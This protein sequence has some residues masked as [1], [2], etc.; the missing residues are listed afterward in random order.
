MQ[1]L[2]VVWAMTLI[3]SFMTFTASLHADETQLPTTK[4]QAVHRS[5]RQPWWVARQKDLVIPNETRIGME[6]DR[7][8]ILAILSIVEPYRYVPAEEWHSPY[9]LDWDDGSVQCKRDKVQDQPKCTP[10]PN[11]E[12]KNNADRDV[13]ECSR[14]DINVFLE[15]CSDVLTVSKNGIVGDCSPRDGDCLPPRPVHDSPLK[16]NIAI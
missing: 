11:I 6:N 13:I 1:S 7:A 12:I 16:E 10:I 14:E 9:C 4:V 3:A 2:S 8:W 5:G 15:I